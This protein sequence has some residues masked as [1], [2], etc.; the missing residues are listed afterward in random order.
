MM[1]IEENFGNNA[2]EFTPTPETVYLISD[3]EELVNKNADKYLHDSSA[4]IVIQGLKVG[5]NKGEVPYVLNR[6]R[7]ELI[8]SQAGRFPELINMDA[9][10][11]F[12][13]ADNSRAP[14]S[15]TYN[16]TEDLH[17]IVHSQESG[18]IILT[19]GKNDATLD[20]GFLEGVT[21]PQAANL[22]EIPQEITGE[23][24]AALLEAVASAESVFTRRQ[25]TTAVDAFT[26]FSLVHDAKIR[27]DENGERHINQELCLEINHDNERGQPDSPNEIYLPP[28]ST[29]RTMLRFGRTE[30]EDGWRFTGSY[31]GKLSTGELLSEVLYEHPKVAMPSNKALEKA[32]FVLDN[33]P[34]N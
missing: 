20:S 13:L 2:A 28:V 33:P 10:F 16:W 29:Y 12:P 9:R 27:N 15:L 31:G 1:R 30:G 8:T 19:Q 14:F 22:F 4:E 17:T 34:E 21:A 24:T 3:L 7:R 25:A 18:T 26:S 11:T 32:L 5:N 23:S 6:I